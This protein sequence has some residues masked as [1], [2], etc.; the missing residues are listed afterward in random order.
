MGMTVDQIVEE[1]RSLPHDVVV[2]LVVGYGAFSLLE[3]RHSLSAKSCFRFAIMSAD[4]GN[5]CEDEARPRDYQEP[6]SSSLG[7]GCS[8]CRHAASFWVGRCSFYGRVN[9][10]QELRNRS[11]EHR[12]SFEVCAS[13]DKTDTR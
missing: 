12:G 11:H 8:F 5:Q 7:R 6:G 1:T 4:L 2:D 9:N 3:K 13:P 10:Y